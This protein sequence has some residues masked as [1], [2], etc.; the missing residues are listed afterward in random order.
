[1]SVLALK[2]C[3]KHESCSA[4]ISASYV[5]HIFLMQQSDSIQTDN[6]ECIYI[7]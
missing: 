5:S 6:L 4:S 2:A 3:I 1:M 7:T